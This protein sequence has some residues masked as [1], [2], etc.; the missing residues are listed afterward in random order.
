MKLVLCG[1]FFWIFLL[2]HFELA[3]VWRDCSKKGG[4]RGKCSDLI[5]IWW[6]SEWL[7]ADFTKI[8][9]LRSCIIDR[10]MTK[11][12]NLLTQNEICCWKRRQVFYTCIWY[13]SAGNLSERTCEYRRDLVYN[14]W[15]LINVNSTEISFE[16]A[17][18]LCPGDW[19]VFLS[20]VTRA[21]T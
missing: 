17:S 9:F 21:H 20:D 3:E 15:L 6:R 8:L 1:L 14:K 18:S 4:S 11:A 10:R 19:N 16:R 12:P 7:F 13:N 5:G 2:Q